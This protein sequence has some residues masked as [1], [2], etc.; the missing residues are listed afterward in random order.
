MNQYSMLVSSSLQKPNTQGSPS[1]ISDDKLARVY[2][3]TFAGAVVD[4]ELF[5]HYRPLTDKHHRR[6]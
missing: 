5:L 2:G 4:F 3:T 6:N 1:C